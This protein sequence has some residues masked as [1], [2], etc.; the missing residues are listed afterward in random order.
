MNSGHDLQK[1]FI[2]YMEEGRSK[3]A[4]I[5]AKFCLLAEIDPGLHQSLCD[6]ASDSLEILSE[7][8]DPKIPFMSLYMVLTSTN[9]HKIQFNSRVKLSLLLYKLRTGMISDDELEDLVLSPDF[10]DGVCPAKQLLCKGL[11]SLYCEHYGN[12]VKYFADACDNDVAITR[13]VLSAFSQHLLNL[14]RSDFIEAREKGLIPCFCNNTERQNYGFRDNLVHAVKTPASIVDNLVETS[15]IINNANVDTFNTFQLCTVHRLITELDDVIR[16]VS[17]RD[18]TAILGLHLK[19]GRSKF[20]EKYFEVNEGLVN[21]ED[22]ERDDGECVDSVNGG[23]PSP[24][25][26]LSFVSV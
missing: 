20:V 17:D 13:A 2:Q 4:L 3:P 19:S 16:L 21:K 25:C 24:Q 1:I 5:S 26:H 12:A 6:Y 10:E 15:F 23:S 11:A 14:F 8:D 18:F 9:R 7:I 22:I